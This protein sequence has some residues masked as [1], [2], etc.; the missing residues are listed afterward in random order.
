MASLVGYITLFGVVTRL[1][2][3]PL[4]LGGGRPGNELRTPMALVILVGPVS[5]T[6]LNIVVR[7]AV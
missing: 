4:A 5:A 1:V 2:L 3:L 7:P 6:T